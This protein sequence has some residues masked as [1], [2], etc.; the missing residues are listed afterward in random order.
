MYT[1]VLAEM[2]NDWMERRGAIS[3]LQ[4]G[5]G[6]GKRAVDSICIIKTI[7]DKYFGKKRGR[8]FWLPIDLQK[9][10]TQ[11]SGIHCDGS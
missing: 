5:F 8:A 6:K 7:T 2:L 3:D 10:L 4:M 1:G 9:A 11:W